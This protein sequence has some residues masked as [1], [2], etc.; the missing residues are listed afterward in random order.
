[1]KY[2]KVRLKTEVIMFFLLLN[3]ATFNTHS[4]PLIFGTGW[5]FPGFIFALQLTLLTTIF[6][7]QMFKI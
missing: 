7:K 6:L 5:E 4:T 1:M 3:C 2:E